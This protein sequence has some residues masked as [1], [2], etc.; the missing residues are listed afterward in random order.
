MVGE[1]GFDNSWF[2]KWR[3]EKV[4][5]QKVELFGLDLKFYTKC[6]FK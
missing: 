5:D 4:R 2:Q 6:S 1:L 3:L